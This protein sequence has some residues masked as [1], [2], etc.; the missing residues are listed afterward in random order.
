MTILFL[1]I[2]L[3]SRK[4]GEGTTGTKAPMRAILRPI[5][6]TIKGGI[7]LCMLWTRRNRDL[8]RNRDFQILLLGRL[9]MRSV[10]KCSR[11]ATRQGPMHNLRLYVSPDLARLL[12]HSATELCWDWR[13]VVRRKRNGL[14][15]GR[16]LRAVSP[17]DQQKSHIVHPAQKARNR[18]RGH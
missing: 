1:L 4:R 9:L 13:P 3:S 16:L 15:R 11:L 10:T 2:G 6:I 7:A 14:H 18:P 12:T 5:T 8:S 17:L